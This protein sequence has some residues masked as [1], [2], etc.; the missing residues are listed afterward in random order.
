MH[1]N[2][3]F[4]TI[5]SNQQTPRRVHV[6]PSSCWR[7]MLIISLFTCKINFLH[8]GEYYLKVYTLF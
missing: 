1:E 8:Q 6:L 5:S 4:I 2:K 7:R 3:L